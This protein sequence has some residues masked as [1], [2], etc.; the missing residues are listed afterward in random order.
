MLIFITCCNYGE[1][2]GSNKTYCQLCQ[3][4][5]AFCNVATR[6]YKI[7]YGA[8][9]I[10]LLESVVWMIIFSGLSL[11][12]HIIRARAWCVLFHNTHSSLIN[13]LLAYFHIQRHISSKLYII[14]SVPL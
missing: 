8:S 5:F 6:K 4:L 11:Y 12:I 14:A 3:R 1:Y 7:T 10:F 2:I 9:I 13:I